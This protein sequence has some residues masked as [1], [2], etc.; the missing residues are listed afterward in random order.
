MDDQ[1]YDDDNLLEDEEEIVVPATPWHNSDTTAIA[2]MYASHMA[3]AASEFFRNLA[4]TA[5]GQSA[6][7]WELLDRKSFIDD[8][9]AS[10]INLPEE[11]GDNGPRRSENSQ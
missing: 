1:D 3:T 8:S 9:L 7:E 5:L 11:G 2:M 10:I 6:H 4:I